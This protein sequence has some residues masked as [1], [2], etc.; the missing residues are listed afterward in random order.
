MCTFFRKIILC[1]TA[2]FIFL[3]SSALSAV[4]FEMEC[5]VDRKLSRETE[6][7]RTKIDEMRYSVIIR[8]HDEG[9]A[10]ISRCDTMAPCDEYEADHFEFTSGVNISKYYYFRGQFDVQVF[11]D[12]R[13]IENN[14]RGTL[15]FGQCLRK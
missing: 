4:N 14:G 5:V 8:H 1:M 6:Y 12:G 3:S 11:N 9:F 7:S 13:F 15:A 2:S 10:T